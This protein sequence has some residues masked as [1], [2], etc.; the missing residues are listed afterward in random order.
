M[1]AQ[2]ELR[3]RMLYESRGFTRKQLEEAAAENSFHPTVTEALRWFV[4]DGHLPWSLA[5]VNNSFGELAMNLAV[6][7]PQQT[8][9]THCLRS[10]LTAKDCAVRA[11]IKEEEDEDAKLTPRPVEDVEPEWGTAPD[12][13]SGLG[14]VDVSDD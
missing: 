4:D 5:A 9:T 14:D 12:D 11:F 7:A 1:A 2:P 6:A 3:N 8:E 10:L 13:L